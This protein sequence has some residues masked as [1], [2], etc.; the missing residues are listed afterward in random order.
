MHDIG[1]EPFL[2]FGAPD[3]QQ[4]E[5]DEV[6]ACLESGWL[7]TGPRVAAFERE[8]AAFVGLPEQNVAALHSC[9]AALHLS[10]LTA[11]LAPGAEVVTTPLTFCATVNA[12]IH[13]GCRP[14][15]ADVSP[16]SMNIDPE[17]ARQAL[18]PE[19]QALA[20]VHFAGRPCDM[21]AL[22]ALAEEKGL[23]LVE[24]CAHAVETQYRGRPAGTFGDFGCYSFYVTKNVACG[25]GGMVVARDR[26]RV[27]RVKT[28]ALHGMSKDAW[29]RFSDTGYQHYFVTECGF[30]YN[31]MDLQAAIGLHQLARVLPN[32][33]RRRAIWAAYDEAFADL[34][35]TLPAP[36]DPGTRHGRHLYTMLL[37]QQRCGI[38][39]DE[40]LQAMTRLGIGVGVHYLSVAEH[41]YYQERFGWRPEEWPE[42]M[43]I[44]RQTVSLPLSPR[45]GDD[46]VA[47]VIDAVRTTVPERR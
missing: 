40:F 28:L 46:D 17:Q 21:D 23:T 38:S 29:H 44:G 1:N 45:L 16:R 14:V 32:L 39:R 18:T 10:L 3:L 5:K 11:G 9:T 13:A 24:D 43:R 47:R 6:L 26:E 25:E 27:N 42:A 33:E 36:E 2:V 30:K 31:M 37:D 4:A 12:I 34:P 19:T 35:V 8:F 7:G 22:C 15:L 41:P 20:P